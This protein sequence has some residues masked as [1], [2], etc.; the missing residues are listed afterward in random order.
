MTKNKDVDVEVDTIEKTDLEDF[1]WDEDL[2]FFGQEPVEKSEEDD[3]AP[4]DKKDKKPKQEPDEP[5]EPPKKPVEK[6]EVLSEDKDEDDVV[7]EP[8]PFS[9]KVPDD[10]LERDEEFFKVLADE[11]KESGVFANVEIG[12]DVSEERFV[13][14]QDEEIESRVNE[15]FEAFFEELDQDGKEFLKFKKAGGSTREFFNVLKKQSDVPKGDMNEVAHQKAFLKYYYQAY[16][17]MDME[18][19]DGHLELLEDGGRLGKYAKR[20]NEKVERLQAEEKKDTRA[21]VENAEKLRDSDRDDYQKKLKDK[22]ESIET[23]GVFPV[24]LKDKRELYP[25]ITKPVQKVGKNSYI[26]QFQADMNSVG[27]DFE[28][29]ILMAKLVRQD[30]DIGDIERKVET[31]KVSRIKEKLS[32]Q[33]KHRR[34]GA[35]GGGAKSLS[36]FFSD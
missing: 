2:V 16:E 4:D 9:E 32:K 20:F 26:T 11:L 13:E 28:K 17:N 29:L 5:E 15:T 6:K 30:F 7:P 14:L 12:D 27:K 36:D 31:K 33:R 23:I 8:D 35:G 22:L 34:P 3:D 21:R 10:K 1:K 25:Y 18:D 24:T 19:I